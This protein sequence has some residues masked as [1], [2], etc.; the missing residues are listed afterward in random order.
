M[1]AGVAFVSSIKPS[2]PEKTR[3]FHQW[4]AATTSL[5]HTLGPN[6]TDANETMLEVADRLEELIEPLKSRLSMVAVRDVLQKIVTKAIAFDETLCGQQSWYYLCYPDPRDNFYVDWKSADIAEGASD[7]GQK[8]KFVIRPSLRRK[9]GR[10][11]K[12]VMLRCMWWTSVWYGFNLDRGE[13]TPVG[14]CMQS[15]SK[16]ICT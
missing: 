1:N 4:K 10:R 16:A 15:S 6:A 12:G 2:E 9:G 14:E 11:G 8:V 7:T 13:Q 5:I 3:Q